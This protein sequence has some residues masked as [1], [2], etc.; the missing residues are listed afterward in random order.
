MTLLIVDDEKLAIEGL[1]YDI[2]QE[3][4]GIDRILSANSGEEAK[5][6][7][8][9]ERV[10]ILICDIE[11]PNELG[12]ELMAWVTEHYPE[13]IRIFLTCHSD[14][15]Y[16]AQAVKLQCLDYLLKPVE[17]EEI[18]GVLR[19]AGRLLADRRQTEVYE[20]YGKLY[21]DGIDE[22][23][24]K[25][26]AGNQVTEE[27]VQYIRRHLEEELSVEEIARQVYVSAT[28]LGRLFKKEYNMTVLDFITE[29]RMKVAAQLLATKDISVPV[30]GAKVGFHNYS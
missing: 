27:A 2:E 25:E 11:M 15:R 9:R 14:F 24:A 22:P 16:A 19:K 30:I 20:Q 5:A 12:T 13:I 28:H 4:L 23:E 8:A 10:D 26:P 1:V 3:E 7:L 18:N 17:P 21:F 29:E 6:V